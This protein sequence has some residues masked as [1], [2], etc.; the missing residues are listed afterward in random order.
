MP[1]PRPAIVIVLDDLISSGRTMQLSLEAIL[2][3]G[4]MALG[5]AFSGHLRRD[6]EA[7]ERLCS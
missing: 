6:I 7:A 2:Q 5:M 1:T 4:I 3:A